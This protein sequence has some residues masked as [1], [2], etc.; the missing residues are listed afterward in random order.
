MVEPYAGARVALD[1]RLP[2]SSLSLNGKTKIVFWLKA[3]NSDVTGWQGGP[4]VMLHRGDQVMTIEPQSGKDW[5]REMEYREAREGWRRFEIPLRGDAKWQ[6][7]GQL[8]AEIDTISLM[9]DSWGAPT[10][11][12]WLDGLAIE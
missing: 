10:L 1:Y 6:V 8:P 2:E 12:F 11:R 7:I 4:F 9:F 5:M 3:I